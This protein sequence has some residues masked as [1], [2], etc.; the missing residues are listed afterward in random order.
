MSQNKDKFQILNG[1]KNA[2]LDLIKKL[3]EIAVITVAL[4]VL[5]SFQGISYTCPT[6]QFQW[7]YFQFSTIAGPAG[8]S[9]NIFDHGIGTSCAT[10]RR[11]CYDG[12]T[13]KAATGS[14]QFIPILPQMQAAYS[15]YYQ[16][17]FC[18]M[19]VDTFNQTQQIGLTNLTQANVNLSSEPGA[20]CDNS[21]LVVTL[22]C[23]FTAM[24]LVLAGE[25]LLPRVVSVIVIFIVSKQ[26]KKKHKTQSFVII[27]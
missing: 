8:E 11:Q 24:L 5:F 20:T 2:V 25:I 6:A 17:C 7:C 23:F 13:Q 15:V 22:V 18:L 4:Y 3:N 27:N 26:F 10:P 9:G 12:I 21:L 1:N 19:K 16:Y 14:I